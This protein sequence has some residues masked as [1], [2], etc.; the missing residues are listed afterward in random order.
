MGYRVS[1]I[2][3]FVFGLGAF[4][5]TKKDVE[6]AVGEE[7]IANLDVIE[8]KRFTIFAAKDEAGVKAIDE[9]ML[10]LDKHN[11]AAAPGYRICYSVSLAVPVA[12]YTRE[13]ELQDGV[14]KSAFTSC[15]GIPTTTRFDRELGKFV[16]TTPTFWLIELEIPVATGQMTFVVTKFGCK[17]NRENHGLLEWQQIHRSE[18]NGGDV[19]SFRYEGEDA[20]DK[21]EKTT[22]INRRFLD[23][24]I[25]AAQAELPRDI[26][27]KILANHVMA[28]RGRVVATADPDEE[29]EELAT[30]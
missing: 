8:S 2:V 6:Q 23:G 26:W 29:V 1:S 16:L 21:V 19:V 20:V 4:G 14:V 13:A 27:Q 7:I 15:R 10:A 28:Q 17:P 24:Q 11:K 18:E 5:A 30:V 22:K 25:E 3:E 12:Q 9:L